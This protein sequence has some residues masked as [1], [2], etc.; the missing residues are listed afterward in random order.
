MEQVAKLDEQAYTEE[1]WK[2][3]LEARTQAEETMAAAYVEQAQ[4]DAAYAKLLAAYQGL[5][6]VT[7]T[8]AQQP[9]T[10]TVETGQT[11]GHPEMF[12]ALLLIAGAAITT[13]IRRRNNAA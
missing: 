6:S 3:L 5:Q 8:P 9:S 2:A 7:Q 13:I 4:V 1:S 12:A 10:P 11:Q